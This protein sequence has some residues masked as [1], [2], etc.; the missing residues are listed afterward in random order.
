M[1][2][3]EFEHFVIAQDPVYD[4]VIRELTAGHKE[5]HWMWFIF[6][7][8]DGLGHSPMSQCFA[9]D[10]L[11]AARRYLQHEILGPRLHECTLL[12]LNIRNRTAE[13]VFG[14]P[15][16]LKFHSSMT[17]FALCT[18]GNIYDAALI[19]YFTGE[20]DPKTLKLLRI[21]KE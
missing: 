4:Q 10:D 8:L 19:K 12:T 1:T 7:Q 21:P 9:L 13:Q 3:L 17:L 6:P 14:T 15:D 5:T 2:K 11:D 16:D 18:P 20:R